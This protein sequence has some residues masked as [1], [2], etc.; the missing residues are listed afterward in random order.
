MLAG[1]RGSAGVKTG[2]MTVRIFE[3]STASNA[4]QPIQANA[5]VSVY[6]AASGTEAILHRQLLKPNGEDGESY[7]FDGL[8]PNTYTIEAEAAGYSHPEDPSVASQTTAPAHGPQRAVLESATKKTEVLVENGSDYEVN[9]YME[10]TNKLSYGALKGKVTGLRTDGVNVG[11]I[12]DVIV[13][14]GNRSAKT[15]SSGDYRIENIMVVGEP[16]EVNVFPPQDGTP[17]WKAP[18]DGV[19]TMI[20]EGGVETVLNIQLEEHLIDE[21][22]SYGT[23]NGVVAAVGEDGETLFGYDF[24]QVFVYI[25]R[26]GTNIDPIQVGKCDSDGKFEITQ[27]P[28]T[29]FGETFKVVV[30][31]P[32]AMNKSSYTFQDPLLPE[33]V[34]TVPEEK[35]ELTIYQGP[36][37]VRYS[38]TS[39]YT[40]ENLLITAIF[41]PTAGTGNVAYSMTI[42]HSGS[43]LG[44]AWD[45]KDSGNSKLPYGSYGTEGTVS[46]TV[47]V[48]NAT[49][50]NASAG[51]PLIIDSPSA[52]E[53]V[54]MVPIQVEVEDN[55]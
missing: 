14:I 47:N 46:G 40:V 26:A 32:N 6:T 25:Y 20:A 12:P 2:S 3:A 52:S 41:K 48:P 19:Q 29:R 7:V 8:P 42:N 44:G 15:N 5:M 16:Q 1:C 51:T 9:L 49:V 50:V 28:T 21:D 35:L 55:P 24:T 4:P 13:A 43:L 18:E 17:L 45:E 37:T 31:S 23:I 30:T 54:T 53:N 33:K 38:N 39:S 27:I 10:K 11:G 36:Y 22:K 34:L